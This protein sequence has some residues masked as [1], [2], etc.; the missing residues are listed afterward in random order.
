MVVV[1]HSR[2]LLLLVI[3]SFL[4]AF[5][6]FEI[7][8]PISSSS[9]TI[10]IQLGESPVRPYILRVKVEK[11]VEPDG[12]V[13]PVARAAVSF[14]E[15]VSLTNTNGYAYFTAL[16]GKHVVTI[17]SPQSFF[18]TYSTEVEINTRVTEVVV[19]FTEYRLR[20]EQINILVDTPAQVTIVTFTQSL[21]SNKTLYV[22]L[23][24]IT[25]IN[26]ENYLKRFIGETTIPYLAEAPAQYSGPFTLVEAS[27]NF[28]NYQT[29]AAVQDLIQLIVVDESFVPAYHVE[30]VI[31]KMG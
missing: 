20:P 19:R 2:T 28:T 13:R 10:D 16:P 1:K 12:L 30:A 3:L 26:F 29:S 9:V 21:V 25:F 22:G 8:P 15:L 23:P 18:P 5:N 6:V 14:N 4:I 27:D 24:Y 7:I 31:F 11:M 17:S